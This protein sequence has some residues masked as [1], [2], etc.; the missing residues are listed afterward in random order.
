MSRA[1][2]PDRRR[3]SIHPF[4]PHIG[5]QI[6]NEFHLVARI[7]Q[8]FLAVTIVFGLGQLLQLSLLVG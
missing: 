1:A 8:G 2:Q 7:A 6:M 5:V 4:D 3:R